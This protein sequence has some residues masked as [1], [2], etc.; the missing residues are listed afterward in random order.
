MTTIPIRII[1]AIIRARND[2]AIRRSR[3][4]LSFRPFLFPGKEKP[5][6]RLSF[7][8]RIPRRPRD[9]RGPKVVSSLSLCSGQA[10]LPPAT[11]LRCKP[12][13]QASGLFVLK[14]RKAETAG[15][16]QDPRTK[17]RNV[18]HPPPRNANATL[19]HGV[20]WPN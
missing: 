16:P 17:R 13:T 6:S 1:A 12:R 7:L 10:N 8:L 19:P 5:K 9:A 4:N 15:A 3:P 2:A 14:D 11:N 18:G 20:G